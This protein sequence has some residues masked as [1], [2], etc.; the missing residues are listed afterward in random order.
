MRIFPLIFSIMYSLGLSAQGWSTIGGNAARNGLVET[1]GPDRPRILWQ[2]TSLE[3]T[4]A[5]QTYLSGGKVVTTR[6]HSNQYAPIVCHDLYTGTQLWVRDLT[7]HTSQSLPIGFHQG[8][9]YALHTDRHGDTLYALHAETGAVKWQSSVPL[10]C[11]H[12]SSAAFTPEGDLIVEGEEGVLVR[13]DHQTGRR[14]WATKCD[15]MA[16]GEL[17]PTV[18][19]DWAY[20]WEW[21]PYPHQAVSMI[22]L[23]TGRKVAT[24]V[25]PS[26]SKLI[27]FVQTP[28]TVG[29]DGTVYA[30][31]QRD[32]LVA[33][34]N[35]GTALQILWETPIL[36]N[37]AYSQVACGP[38]GSIY[39]PHNGKIVRVNGRTGHIIDST[40]TLVRSM[41]GGLSA[42]LA[43]D[44]LGTVYASVAEFPTGT[45]YAFTHNLKVRWSHEVE[46]LHL[47]GPALSVEGLLTVAG[48]GQEL[49]VFQSDQYVAMGG[50]LA[51]ERKYNLT[52][53][54]SPANSVSKLNYSLPQPQDIRIK[55][56]DLAGKSVKTWKFP[57][58][59]AGDHELAIDLPEVKVNAGTYIL[60]FETEE[61]ESIRKKV[62][63]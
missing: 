57:K 59:E 23:A 2:G 48:S 19:G 37:S 52:L 42:R 10:R 62:T 6:R 20:V 47:S 38:D 4:T 54:P 25:I 3:A 58:Q 7:H 12:A 43:V 22:E 21:A 5:N 44:A 36:G 16:R 8:T 63:K 49:I 29:P 32:K 34:R 39:L 45:V 56:Q 11:A 15:P 35:T 60:T 40:R 30:Y 1:I 53:T 26:H 28:I 13:I 41:A 51:S 9:V 50:Q 33:L 55:L 31:K 18:G 61:G 24:Q 27:A 46:G 17:H 14:L